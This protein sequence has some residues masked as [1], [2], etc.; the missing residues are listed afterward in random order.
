MQV[1][2]TGTAAF[3]IPTP[4]A[5]TCTFLRA[6]LVAAH[7]IVVVTTH[8]AAFS[9]EIECEGAVTPD[10]A[11]AW[12]NGASSSTYPVST[13]TLGEPWVQ[14]THTLTVVAPTLLTELNL[15]Y[16]A[17]DAGRTMPDL[18][19]RDP[20]G[21]TAVS[22]PRP[23]KHLRVFSAAHSS[24]ESIDFTGFE[25]IEFIECFLAN[26]L[27]TVRVSNLPNVRRICFEDCD[28]EALDISD[29]PNL[30][31]LRGAVNA[32]TE[33][34][35]GGTTGPKIYHWCTRDNPQLTQNF[36]DDIFQRLTALEEMWTWNDNQTG[37]LSPAS[38]VLTSILAADN[39]Y[40]TVELGAQPNLIECSLAGNEVTSFSISN[41]GQLRTLDLSGNHLPAAQI[42]LVLATMDAEAPLL[43]SLNLLYNDG[44]ATADGLAHYSNL[45]A[46]GV[47][48]MLDMPE[49]NDGQI[50]V[51]GGPSAVT[52]TTDGAHASM[53]IQLNSPAESIIWHW[54]DGTVTAGVE[55][56]SHDFGA[57]GPHTNY[58]EVIPATAVR[59]FGA[60]ES[61]S[62]SVTGVYS[63]AQFPN[64][65]FLFL[66]NQSVTELSLAGCSNLRQ[67]H[68]AGN[69]AST[70]VVDQWFID[71][72]AAVT[73]P[74]SGL[75]EFFYPAGVRSSASDAA[76]S[77]LED[78]GFTI[79]PY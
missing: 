73:G 64:L 17:G 46:R 22:F 55:V 66:F 12:S 48:V 58:V 14:R 47:E 74:I 65:D 79:I 30:E 71:M 77:S 45:M 33:I 3:E 61:S 76:V 16:D 49:T 13:V 54:G 28:L 5:G 42:D 9:P 35:A 78:K 59:Y 69:P 60:Q 27:R 57:A 10:F 29:N 25:R 11:W 26:R 53:Q 44:L 70:A 15:G 39:H 40:E 1:G 67:L 6:E 41:C 52:F 7:D 68:L 18:A 31:D 51:A 8:G 37:T 75:N 63:L 20:Q 62:Q 21:I 38:H 50:D 72:D 23:L 2:A 32:Y 4:A 43:E 24:I 36:N 56:A 19:F 34:I